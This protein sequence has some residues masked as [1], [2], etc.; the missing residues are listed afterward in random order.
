MWENLNKK[1]EN[2]GRSMFVVLVTVPWA[3]FQTV[4]TTGYYNKT[5]DPV[6][7]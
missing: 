3:G 4:A 1:V 5:D 6:G 2:Q 7:V